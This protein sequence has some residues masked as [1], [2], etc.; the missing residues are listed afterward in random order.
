MEKDSTQ[1][2]DIKKERNALSLKNIDRTDIGIYKCVGKAR[3]MWRKKQSKLVSDENEPDTTRFPNLSENDIEEIKNANVKI[4]TERSTKTW[5]NVWS[6]WCSARGITQP[7][8][9]FSYEQLDKHLSKFY[10]EVKKVNGADYE[11]ESLRVM[12]AAIDRY[13]RDKNYGESI[14]SSKPFHQSIKTLNAK[15][16][17][18]RQQGMGKRPNKAEALN[19]SEKET[20]WENGSLGDHSPVAL[21]NA[22]FKC[23]SEQMGLR[24]RQDHYDAYVEDFTIRRHDDGSESIVFNENPT[25]TR[26]GGLRVAKRILAAT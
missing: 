7:I 20:L 2:G 19:Q 11:T 13:L 18:L 10:A 21:T 15:A 24:G 22:N 12:Q 26:S 1:I 9:L 23:L 25:K 8:E 17:S 5:L 14:I 6:N 16:A 4:N 3:L